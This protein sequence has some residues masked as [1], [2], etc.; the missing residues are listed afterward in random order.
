MKTLTREQAISRIKD[1][2]LLKQVDH[3]I[4]GKVV[5]Y[6]Y[7][8]GAIEELKMIFDIKEEEL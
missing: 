4:E 1:M 5:P 8:N 7:I 3:L 6:P 2:L